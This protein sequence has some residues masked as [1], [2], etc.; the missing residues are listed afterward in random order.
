VITVRHAESLS[1]HTGTTILSIAALY[2]AS[3]TLNRAAARRNAYQQ[4][5]SDADQHLHDT[6]TSVP[7]NKPITS[8]L[9]RL[10]NPSRTLVLA[11]TW[12]LHSNAF[13]RPRPVLH[14][15][16]RII[17]H[18]HNTRKTNS[19][20]KHL[21]HL[22]ESIKYVNSLPSA[23]RRTSSHLPNAPLNVALNHPRC[24]ALASH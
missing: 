24:N 21:H 9:I 22:I 17:R 23:L 3:L 1:L 11:L 14:R 20:P 2:I 7:N 4:F 16:C 12:R 8:D 18:E 15:H 6:A 19:A 10:P 5:C 13:S